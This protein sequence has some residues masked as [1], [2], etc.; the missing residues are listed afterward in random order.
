MTRADLPV[1]DIVITAGCWEQ[2]GDVSHMVERAL[3]TSAEM[4][5]DDVG[6]AEVAVMLADDAALKALN[7]T[8]RGIDKPTNVL[9]FPAPEPT[10]PFRIGDPPRHLGDI[11][12]AYETLAREAGEEGK[13][14]GHHLSHLVV[15][16]FLHLM[17]HDHI[18]DG[19]AEEMEALESDILA[20]LG[21]PADAATERLR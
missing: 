4:V 8:W 20:A 3:L 15:H 5:E 13:T 21:Y 2:Q 7:A 9:S 1:I 16:G 6:E 19:E 10:Q 18:D 14:F 17:G 12:I 11:A